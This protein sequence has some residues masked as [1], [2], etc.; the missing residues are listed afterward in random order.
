V[1]SV[2][3]TSGS[4]EAD[5][6]TH[7]VPLERQNHPS[8][9]ASMEASGVAHVAP[10]GDPPSPTAPR[11]THNTPPRASFVRIAGSP[12]TRR[13]TTATLRH[14]LAVASDSDA[15]AREGR[16]GR[17][18]LGAVRGDDSGP[19]RSFQVGGLD[20]DAGLVEWPCGGGGIVAA[21]EPAGT[22]EGTVVSTTMD[23]VFDALSI[24][25]DPSTFPTTLATA[26]HDSQR[27]DMP[28]DPLLEQLPLDFGPFVQQLE[29]LALELGAPGDERTSPSSNGLELMRTSTN[30]LID[31]LDSP[32]TEEDRGEAEGA[33]VDT[34]TF[35]FPSFSSNST[36]S[37][38]GDFA[39]DHRQDSTLVTP[40]DSMDLIDFTS[41]V[42][43]SFG[44]LPIPSSPNHSLSLLPVFDASPKSMSSPL[45]PLSLGLARYSQV[46]GLVEQNEGEP[47][48]ELEGGEGTSRQV[49]Y[50]EGPVQVHDEQE[51]ESEESEEEEE[52]E[53]DPD[54]HPL[55]TLLS[56]STL[57]A[58]R[59]TWYG[60]TLILVPPRRT[61]PTL[62]RLSATPTGPVSPVK[63]GFEFVRGGKGVTGEMT[64]RDAEKDKDH[65][66]LVLEA[67]ETYVALHA[68]RPDGD[69]WK[70]VGG[71]EEE[72]YAQV[73]LEPA[74]GLAH[75]EWVVGTNARTWASRGREPDPPS[76][77]TSS[78]N[79]PHLSQS[80]PFPLLG[81]QIS[82]DSDT[83]DVPRT[84]PLLPS[85]PLA[86][87]RRISGQS[88]SSITPSSPPPR[89]P[90]TLSKR[91]Q[92]IPVI[93]LL[94]PRALQMVSETTIYRRLRRPATV[95]SEAP[96][97]PP[98]IPVV[99]VSKPGFR[100]PKW[101]RRGSSAN[102]LPV[103]P[104]K[105]FQDKDK[106]RA[107]L[108]ERVRVIALDGE[109]AQGWPGSALV[110]STM[111]KHVKKT[112]TA[113]SDQLG[114]VSSHAS[115]LMFGSSYDPTFA[116]AEKRP[117]RAP[118]V[119]SSRSVASGRGVWA[120]AGSGA[121]GVGVG[122]SRDFLA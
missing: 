62:A 85:L 88:R 121:I 90:T 117:R 86:A 7:V 1:S 26:L 44:V 87:L 70:S 67:L 89:S 58:L 106:E 20:G 97:P 25:F 73:R 103:I 116:V 68:F 35:D 69:V 82:S 110:A 24:P 16:E 55:Y 112:R 36:R 118:S 6:L 108:L 4:R 46:D 13:V 120:S 74:R 92:S 113:N 65:D 91:P 10:S 119:A 14:E 48:I 99:K 29:D 84:P 94:P 72:G 21:W 80:I 105:G 2:A 42:R 56:T 115:L 40:R 114:R 49:R 50:D 12:R 63:P 32:S 34:R 122:G 9:L 53:E 104:A 61:L 93:S 102:A 60:S 15:H 54:S 66:K 38:L 11:V 96:P 23:E 45:R 30:H 18:S 22:E 39:I 31:D 3:N 78:L 51:E 76:A 101:L 59:S 41:P 95:P 100:A 107:P 37:S 81:L 43:S 71:N 8:P 5:A 109:I 111:I 75:V 79:I 19:L 28:P 47:N 98:P 83:S 52:E 33:R 27:M 57:P 64:G 17:L 77:S